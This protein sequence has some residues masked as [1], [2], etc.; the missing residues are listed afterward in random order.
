MGV[1][2]NL[3]GA[4]AM[5]S[6]SAIPPGVSRGPN[7]PHAGPP[8]PAARPWLWYKAIFLRRPGTRQRKRRRDMRR[9]GR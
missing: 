5:L 2:R 3:L 1:W 9:A 4:M 8:D 6:A 7:Q